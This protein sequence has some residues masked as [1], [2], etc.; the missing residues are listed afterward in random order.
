MIPGMHLFLNGMIHMQQLFGD[1]SFYTT[2][3]ILLLKWYGIVLSGF[4]LYLIV[5]IIN[6]VQYAYCNIYVIY[7]K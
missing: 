1:I 5:Y 3:R 7:I 4:V 2:Q 6:T